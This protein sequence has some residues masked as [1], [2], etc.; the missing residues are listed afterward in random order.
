MN[1]KG[2]SFEMVENNSLENIGRVTDAIWT[3]FDGDSWVDLIVVGEWMTPK[4]FR[5]NEGDLTDYTDEV[6]DQDLTGLYQAIVPYDI[7]ADGEMDYLLGNW[8]LN[9][10]F[11]AS[12]DHPLKMYHADFDGNGRAETIVAYWKDGEYY[13]VA[14]LDELAGQMSFLKRKFTSYKDFAGQPVEEIFNKEQLAKASLITVSNLAS[15][16]LLNSGGKFTFKPFDAPLQVAPLTT[17]LKFDFNGDGIEEVL[18]AGNYFGVSP[19]HGRLGSI[20]GI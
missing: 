3:D 2:N 9:S 11:F 13:P 19:Y 4:F 12:E 5:N 20:A 15:G 10:K 16:Y 6:F 18:A 8:G 1:N 17:F 14:G 7:N